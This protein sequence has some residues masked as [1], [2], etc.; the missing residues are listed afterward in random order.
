ML[1]AHAVVIRLKEHQRKIFQRYLRVS[2][3]L[4]ILAEGFFSFFFWMTAYLA[5]MEGDSWY[6]LLSVIFILGWVFFCLIG[7]PSLLRKYWLALRT[8]LNTSWVVSSENITVKNKNAIDKNYD[9]GSLESVFDCCEFP[10]IKRN[11]VVFAYRQEKMSVPR[12]L[13]NDILEAA[14]RLHCE[15]TNIIRQ[16]LSPER[17]MLTRREKTFWVVSIVVIVISFMASLFIIRAS[18]P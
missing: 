5:F 2:K 7:F 9:W 4:F 16:F 11:M 1:L 8:F 13:M 14:E 10:E 17:K 18:I 12:C 15:N 6:K 3:Y